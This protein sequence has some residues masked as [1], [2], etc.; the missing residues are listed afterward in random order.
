MSALNWIPVA[1]RLPDAEITVLCW[2]DTGEW[3]SGWFDGEFWK[4]AATGDDLDGVTHWA[5][6]EGPSA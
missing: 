6:P 4:D 2:L 1:E 3:F 5:E